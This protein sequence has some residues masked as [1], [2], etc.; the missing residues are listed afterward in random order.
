VLRSRCTHVASIV[1]IFPYYKLGLSVIQRAAVETIRVITP[2]RRTEIDEKSP[3]RR[4]SRTPDRNDGNRGGVPNA[5]Y[6]NRTKRGV[7][8]V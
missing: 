4:S 6:V 7:F 1:Y 8:D 2:A 3:S 5:R